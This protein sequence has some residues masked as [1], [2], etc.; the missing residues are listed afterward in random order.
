MTEEYT[1]GRSQSHSLGTAPVGAASTGR[2]Q[3]TTALPLKIL[4]P[5]HVAVRWCTDSGRSPRAPVWTS[6]RI[7]VSAR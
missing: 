4:R 1:E 6:V 7:R 5:P 3:S 2:R